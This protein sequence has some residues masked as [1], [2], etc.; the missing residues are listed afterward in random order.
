MSKITLTPLVNLQNE[1]TAVSAIN[2]NNAIIQTAMDNTLSRD[3]TNPNTMNAILDMNS[4]QIIN[5]PAPTTVNSPARLVDVVTNPTIVIPTTGTS[6]HTVPFLDG[7]NTFSGTDTFNGA[8]TLGSTI[9]KLTLTQPATSATLTIPDTVVLTGPAAS[10]TV[11]TLGNNETVTGVKTFGGAG[12]VSKLAIAGTTSGSTILNATAVASGTLTLPIGADTLVGR[13]STDTLTNKTFNSSATGNVLQ[14]SGVTVSN[15][16]YPGEPTT[17][18]AT[19]GNV[20]ELMTGTLLS[21]S[22]VTLTTGVAA[23]VIGIALPAGDWN[24]WGTVWLLPAGSTT[25]TLQ[26]VYITS[27]NSVTPTVPAPNVALNQSW[28]SLPAGGGANLPTGTCTFSFSGSTSIFLGCNITFA[29]STM[30][31]FGS[32]WARRAR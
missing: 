24:V 19:A 18:V 26:S 29:V 13:A 12:N 21:A 3:G 17:G 28:M 27:V 16:Q 9:N 15:G 1:T 14:V 6:G 30:K 11:M 7:N 10:G 31:A 23:N 4:N 2:A 22:A 32:I 5:L 20:G 25:S 8:V